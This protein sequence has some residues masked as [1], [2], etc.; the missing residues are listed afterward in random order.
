MLTLFTTKKLILPLL[1]LI[2]GGEVYG[3]ISI[4]TLGAANTQNFN[5]LANSGTAQS[6]LSGWEMAEAPGYDDLY[7]AGDGSSST[8]GIY[9]YGIGTNSDRAW[10]SLTASLAE[11]M[12]IGVKYTNDAA[13]NISSVT[14]QYTGEQ[15]R[16]GSTSL[17]D[18]LNF[19]YSTDATSVTD[20]GATWIAVTSLD[21]TSPVTTGTIGALDGNSVAN[22]TT[23]SANI[24]VNIP[25][26]TGFI[27][28]RWRD[29]QLGSNDHALAIDD[30]SLTAY[31]NLTSGTYADLMVD[32]TMT[33]GG[34][35]TISGS[36]TFI[37][38]SSIVD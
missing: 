35:I 33:L 8:A 15:W 2:M 10:G 20:N 11:P 5:G 1:L 18:K 30:L 4:T 38:G 7:D 17:S 19:E 16:L 21:F 37:N 36:T 27:F 24:A 25:T 34:D 29:Q 6:P 14:I 9:S 13:Q 3:Q 12:I 26:T 32:G 31:A 28:I 23:L 22:R